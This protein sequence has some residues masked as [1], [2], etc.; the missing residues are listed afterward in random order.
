MVESR[1]WSEF[2]C[3]LMLDSKAAERYLRPT[4]RIVEQDGCMFLG[5]LLHT[6]GQANAKFTRLKPQ[7]TSK[8]LV[9]LAPAFSK[10]VLE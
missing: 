9:A 10:I 1:L 5:H 7:L 2:V 8:A 3:K 4:K 6:A